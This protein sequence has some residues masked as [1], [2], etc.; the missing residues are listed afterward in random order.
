MEAY[1]FNYD[2][3]GINFNFGDET[4]KKPFEA[5]IE[6]CNLA[7]IS[8]LYKYIRLDASEIDRV[9][10]I[11][12]VVKKF[13]N[14]WRHKVIVGDIDTNFFV[15]KLDGQTFDDLFYSY[16]A[17]A[18]QLEIILS[19]LEL[20][21]LTDDTYKQ[22]FINKIHAK[23][24]ETNLFVVLKICNAK[25]FGQLEKF[26]KNLPYNFKLVV[27]KNVLQGFYFFIKQVVLEEVL[28]GD[29]PNFFKTISIPAVVSYFHFLEEKYKL[30][31]G[32]DSLE[33][34]AVCTKLARFYEKHELYSDAQKTWKRVLDIYEKVYKGDH[35]EVAIA[36]RNLGMCYQTKQDCLKFTGFLL[37]AQSM[38][39]RLNMTED[40]KQLKEYFSDEKHMENAEYYYFF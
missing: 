5:A 17:I 35:S 1:W 28:S 6:T 37:Q 23:L 34:A 10:R 32:A 8:C 39:K 3:P 38:F 40:Y 25:Y 9:R 22:I 15:L 7:V 20:E 14:V 13:D 26:A 30:T 12:E 29:T 21:K 24:S 4:G 2:N 36:S 27:D 11:V 31:F 33:E 19:P 18:E 16:F